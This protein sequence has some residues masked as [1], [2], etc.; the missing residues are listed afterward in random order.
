M[1]VRGLRERI[2][3][4]AQSWSDLTVEKRRAGAAISQEGPSRRQIGDS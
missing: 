4:A 1:R 2:R 3:R